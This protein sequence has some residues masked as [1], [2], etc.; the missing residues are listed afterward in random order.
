M[1][2]QFV[3]VIP[4][5]MA[6]SIMRGVGGREGEGGGQEERGRSQGGEKGEGGQGERGKRGGREE[7]RSRRRG[8]RRGRR[9]RQSLLIYVKSTCNSFLLS[10]CFFY[11]ILPS[12]SHH[13]SPHL[14]P[15]SPSLSHHILPSP[16]CHALPHFHLTLP[17][18]PTTLS[19]SSP[20]HSLSRS[21]PP[22]LLHPL[23]PPLSPQPIIALFRCKPNAPR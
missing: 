20:P 13:P 16:L 11:S 6:F 15:H 3:Q 1:N 12:H 23:H 5:F 2:V 14:L 4:N 8:R 18:P 10:I 22:H 19:L 9:G 7:G 21:L 17:Y